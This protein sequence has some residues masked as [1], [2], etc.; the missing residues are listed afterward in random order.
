MNIII[1]YGTGVAA[2]PKEVL[3]VMDR[4]TKTDLRLLLLLVQCTCTL[5]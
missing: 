1:Q 3:K 5:R 4:A 2:L